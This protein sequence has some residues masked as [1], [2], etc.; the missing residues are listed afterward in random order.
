MEKRTALGNTSL[1][2]KELKLKLNKKKAIAFEAISG[3]VS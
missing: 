3:F 1:S 2:R